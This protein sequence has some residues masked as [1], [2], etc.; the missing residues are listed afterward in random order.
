M[1]Q[2]VLKTILENKCAYYIVETYNSYVKSFSSEKIVTRYLA[3]I[4]LPDNI[5]EIIDN[6]TYETITYA[7]TELLK[8]TYIDKNIFIYPKYPPFQKFQSLLYYANDIVPLSN[9]QDNLSSLISNI[10][11]S[12][13]ETCYDVRKIINDY[14]PK[15]NK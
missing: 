10:I 3:L 5:Q 2:N 12:Q 1:N 8:K 9:L 14:L 4:C 15:D 13:S 6:R 7:E 11:S